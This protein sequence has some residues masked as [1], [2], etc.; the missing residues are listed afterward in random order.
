MRSAVQ[1]RS[2]A[3]NYL[4]KEYGFYSKPQVM[5]D[6][7]VVVSLECVGCD[8]PGKSRYHFRKN[9]KIQREKL[10]LKK[11]CKFCKK[12]NIHRETK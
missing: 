6:N 11:Y 12:H 5:G 3:F 4:E 8:N 1:S 7:I 2:W 9:K 10:E